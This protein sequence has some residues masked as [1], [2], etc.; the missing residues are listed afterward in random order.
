MGRIVAVKVWNRPGKEFLESKKEIYE[1]DPNLLEEIRS[2]SSSEFPSIWAARE[3]K[4]YAKLKSVGI[5]CTTPILSFKNILVME[6]EVEPLHVDLTTTFANILKVC[7]QN[8]LQI[9]LWFNHVSCNINLEHFFS[10]NCIQSMKGLYALGMVWINLDET[11]L[12]NTGL[13]FDAGEV[14]PITHPQA[15]EKMFRNCQNVYR[16]SNGKLL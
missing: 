12:K 16:V 7:L 8:F 15:M 13:I 6:M 9:K 4:F 1:A 3:L 10:L 14:L 11:N 5:L 2:S